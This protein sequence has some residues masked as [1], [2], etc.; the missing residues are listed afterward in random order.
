M[1]DVAT[2]SLVILTCILLAAAT[3]IPTFIISQLTSLYIPYGGLYSLIFFGISALGVL[4]YLLC[5]TNTSEFSCLK[6]SLIQ[7]CK[8]WWL[9]DYWG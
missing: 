6:L 5:A 2:F 8:L 7:I 4:T 9:I 3:L 1:E